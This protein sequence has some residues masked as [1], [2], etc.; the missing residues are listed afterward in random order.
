MKIQLL[1]P[2][3]LAWVL[4]TFGCGAEVIEDEDALTRDCGSFCDAML[5][6]PGAT[7]SAATCVDDCMEVYET[8]E[9]CRGAAAE[10]TYCLASHRDQVCGN[11]FPCAAQSEAFNRCEAKEE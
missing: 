2:G 1:V 9:T 3:L 4:G 8:S 11:P 10:V 5:A 6:C 7:V